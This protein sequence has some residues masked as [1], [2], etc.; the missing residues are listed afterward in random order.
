MT[1][2]AQNPFSRRRTRNPT[3]RSWTMLSVTI[4]G[5]SP[6]HYTEAYVGLFR[7]SRLYPNFYNSFRTAGEGGKAGATR[8]P[9]HPGECV[10][11]ASGHDY[12]LV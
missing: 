11:P 5:R 9:G 12:F 4:G 3:R 2:S 8:F 6:R 1:A 7:P 10:A